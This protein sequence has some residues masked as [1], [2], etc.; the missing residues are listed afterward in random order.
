[1]KNNSLTSSVLLF[2]LC[3]WNKRNG[4]IF[5]AEYQL[6]E[7]SHSVAKETA[8]CCEHEGVNFE[9]PCSRPKLPLNEPHDDSFSDLRF[10][11]YWTAFK[12]YSFSILYGDSTA[13]AQGHSYSPGN[14]NLSFHKH[15]LEPA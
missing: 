5:P 7:S 9:A 6:G 12:S 3:A 13:R 11:P 2:L 10:Q 1:M 8:F 4:L 14:F 15:R